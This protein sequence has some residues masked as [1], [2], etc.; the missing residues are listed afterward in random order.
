MKYGQ[1]NTFEVGARVRVVGKTSAHRGETGV[2]CDVH[3]KRWAIFVKFA[4][5]KTTHMSGYELGAYVPEEL[6]TV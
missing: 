1:K 4:C 5:P 6:E 2:I 3:P